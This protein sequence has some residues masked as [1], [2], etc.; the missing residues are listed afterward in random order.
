MEGG[1]N[2]RSLRSL[3]KQII[4]FYFCK[5]IQ[6]NLKDMN[7]CSIEGA[8]TIQTQPQASPILSQGE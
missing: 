4:H 2:R 7:V 1:R 3:F 8:A 6:L 5:R